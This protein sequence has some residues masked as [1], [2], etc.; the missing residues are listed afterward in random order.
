MGY[1]KRVTDICAGA[2]AFLCS[3]FLIRRYMEF[4]P[5]TGAK[6]PSKLEQ[7]LKSD[8]KEDYRLMISL[9]IIL[10]LSLAV[11][12]I[13]RRIPYLCFGASLLPVVH[14]SYMLEKNLL[15]DQTALILILI[16]LHALGNLAECLNRDNEDGRHRLSIAAKISSAMGA[17]LCFYTIWLSKGETPK[18]TKALGELTLLE[19]DMLLEAKPLDFEIISTFFWMFVILLAVSLLLYNVYFIDAIL[20]LVPAV[21][22]IYI[23][24]SGNL[25]VASY[26]FLSIAI[27]CALTHLMLAV[28][29]NN[30]S[31]KEQLELK[32]KQA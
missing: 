29:Q 27:I 14:A 8:A 30:L 15:Y 7:F 25:G 24:A 10:L 31:R 13:F 16:A 28:F 1:F 21:Y 11:S 26:I 2:A 6:D 5:T 22:A 9:V 18:D 17:I 32:E 19:Q 12:V 20:A 23:N 3:V 4:K